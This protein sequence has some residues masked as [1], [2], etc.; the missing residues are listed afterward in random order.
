MKNT[1]LGQDSGLVV[2]RRRLLQT[3]A[4]LAGGAV[5]PAGLTLPAYADDHPAIGT[6]PAGTS[7]SSVFIGITVPRTGT[8]AVH[9]EDEL[10][11]YQL[12]VEHLNVSNR[13]VKKISPKTTKGVLG[14]QLQLGV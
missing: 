13:R 1:I 9:G 14:K 5:L 12:V 7:G 8:Y 4:G 6:Y 3:A 10:K 2:S 11:G